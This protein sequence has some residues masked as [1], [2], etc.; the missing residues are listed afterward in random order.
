MSVHDGR[1]C[2]YC[3]N[4]CFADWCDVDVGHVQCGPYHCISCLA[5]E[6]GPHDDLSGRALSAK[7]KDCGWY[8]PYSEPGTSAN[9]ICGVIVSHTMK[10]TAYRMI[11]PVCENLKDADK[12]IREG[13]KGTVYGSQA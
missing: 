9:V 12:I 13:S 11:A 7:E 3:G 8:E 6:I 2:P 5:S 1:A 10:E 4:R